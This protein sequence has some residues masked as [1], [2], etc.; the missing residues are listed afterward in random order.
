M[1]FYLKLRCLS[2]NIITDRHRQFSMDG[3]LQALQYQ[4]E[5]TCFFLQATRIKKASN[6]FSRYCTFLSC[7][8]MLTCLDMRR[9][10][11]LP[12]VVVQSV[13]LL[14]GETDGRMCQGPGRAISQTTLDTWHVTS[15]TMPPRDKWPPPRRNEPGWPLF[16]LVP[17]PSVNVSLARPP[18]VSHGIACYL[19]GRSWLLS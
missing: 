2:T 17:D 4:M 7:Q 3:S 5:T 18:S 6:R 11:L 1:S 13:E 9:N 8:T 19:V 12:P 10:F 15:V 16:M 14:S